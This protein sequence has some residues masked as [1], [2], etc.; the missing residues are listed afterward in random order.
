LASL[1]KKSGSISLLNSIF[2]IVFQKQTVLFR[3]KQ[4]DMGNKKLPTFLQL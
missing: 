1:R 3:I 2:R 4:S